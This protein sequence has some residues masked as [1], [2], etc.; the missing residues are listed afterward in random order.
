M[1]KYHWREDLNAQAWDRLL[2]ATQGHP[3]Q[4]AR[5]GDARKAID[6]IED[7]RLAAFSGDEAVYLAR[8]E[9]RRVLNFFKI[10]WIP[11][12]PTVSPHANEPALQAAFF[13]QLRQR[14]FLCCTTTPWKKSNP[15]KIS[16][17]P[18]H[19]IWLDLTI[20]KE[21]LWRNL[22]KQCRYDVR[23]AKKKGVIVEKTTSQADLLSFYALCQS[24]SHTKKFALSGSAALLSQL[25]Q[26]PSQNGV[27]SFLFKA[28]LQDKLCGG[29]FVIRCGDSVHYMWAASDRAFSQCCIGEYLQW[30]IIEWALGQQCKLYDLEGIDPIQ[31][32]GTYHFKKKF[33][34]EIITLPGNQIHI[35]NNPLKAAIHFFNLPRAFNL[36]KIS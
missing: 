7:Y 23:Q 26:N 14:G 25:T 21:A 9:K 18:T 16:R 22:S 34:G 31:N 12:G 27:E 30:E 17:S 35:L 32:P 36:K 33:G 3:L 1:E 15:Q 13:E 29:A 19:T 10:A 8:F 4:S 5:W 11:C 20:G 2:A 6:G 28:L 24:V